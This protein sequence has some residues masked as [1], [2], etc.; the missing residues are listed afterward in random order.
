[1]D[2]ESL[3]SPSKFSEEECQAMHRTVIVLFKKWEI[4][5]AQAAK[6][7]GGI[8]VT[9]HRRW[10]NGKLRMIGPDLAERMSTLLGIHKSL[11]LLFKDPQRGYDWIKRQSTFFQMSALEVMLNGNLADLMRVRH[12]LETQLK[13]NLNRSD[14]H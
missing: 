10:K 14:H 11:R 3:I 8:S 7:L 6:L 9:T 13:P 12:Y 4:T 1:M 2:H 5:D